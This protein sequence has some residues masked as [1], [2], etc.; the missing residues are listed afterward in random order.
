MVSGT[1]VLTMLRAAA[2]VAARAGRVGF[3]RRRLPGVEGGDIKRN[4][5][6]KSSISLQ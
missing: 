6:A 3:S 1:I 4:K 2:D 5:A